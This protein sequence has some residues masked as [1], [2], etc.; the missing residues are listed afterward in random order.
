VGR[1]SSGHGGGYE[2]QNGGKR[3]NELLHVVL[4]WFPPLAGLLFAANLER[5]GWLTPDW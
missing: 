4:P 2:R 3:Q 1:Y 5:F